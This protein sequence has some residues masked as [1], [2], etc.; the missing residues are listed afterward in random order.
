M[1]VLSR[2]FRALLMLAAA[3]LTLDAAEGSSVPPAVDDFF[4]PQVMRNVRISPDG[5]RIAYVTEIEGRRG[6]A[7]FD[8]ATAKSSVLVRA[9]DENIDSFFWKGNDFIVYAADVG[10]NE[11]YAY[12]SIHL[13]DR[14][15]TRLIES[16]GENNLTRQGG[17]YGRIIDD[18]RANP[19]KIILYGSREESSWTPEFYSADVVTGRRDAV[20]SENE[21]EHER[22]ADHLFDQAGRMRVRVIYEPKEA[23]VEARIGQSNTWRLLFTQP[24]DSELSGLPH[25]AILADNRT[26]VFV[27]YRTKD[28]GALVKWDLD[29]GRET[30]ELFEPP[31]GEITAVTLSNDR[32]RVLGVAYEGEKTHF[33]WFDEARQRMQAG[34]E[35]T[36][37]GMTTTILS[38]SDDDKRVVIHVAS[39]REPG[40]YFLADRT[41]PTSKL[42]PLGSTNPRVDTKKLAPM[43]PIAF[44]AR[45]G[46]ELHGYLTRPLNHGAKPDPLVIH[47]HGGPYGIRDDWGYNR[48]VQLLASHGYAVLQ[49]NYRGSGGYGRRFLEAGRREWGGKMQDDLTDAVHWAIE[50]GIADPKRVAIYGASYGGYAALAGAAYAPD[51]Y[52]CAINYVGVS[53]LALLGQRDRGGWPLMN[54]LYYDQWLPKDPQVLHDR[55]PVYAVADI[56]IP[57]LHAYGENDPRVEIRHW[58]RLREELDRLHKPYEFVRES[59]EGHGFRHTGAEQKF[60]GQL[61]AF[62][63]KYAPT[64]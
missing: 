13:A 31:A 64:N 25:A 38:A 32:S 39:D 42:A 37:P 1:H 12:Q 26:F 29:E 14:R 41:G 15:I 4:A 52:C 7:L 61:I 57:T 44:K 33:H 30:G 63:E 56:K 24:R 22:T 20:L 35:H 46:L 5:N 11:A 45:D 6:I 50:Q 48:E 51:L 23:R 40:G 3:A 10:G 9:A 47:P 28:R 8:V 34:L 53:D 36:F 27:D 55:S 21:A 19:R 49:V 54:E 16:W 2:C 60:Y 18:W 59:D 58:K 43:A 17:Q 62:L